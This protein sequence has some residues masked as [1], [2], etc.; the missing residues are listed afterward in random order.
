MSD[1]YSEMSGKNSKCP[2]RTE[3]L[4]HKMSSKAQINLV[5][6][7]LI[8]N[9]LIELDFYYHHQTACEYHANVEELEISFLS[10]VSGMNRA[11]KDQYNRSLQCACACPCLFWSLS[12]PQLELRKVITQR[13]WG[14][15]FFLTLT[16]WTSSWEYASALFHLSLTWLTKNLGLSFRNS[17][18]LGSYVL[19]LD[20]I[21]TLSRQYLK[22]Q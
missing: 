9:S 12:L 17:G 5:Y 14:C 6:S 21:L 11:P 4:P 22:I 18:S 20:D 7:G 10:C 8:K 13:K 19:D 3:G 1:L 16:S 2:T 15:N